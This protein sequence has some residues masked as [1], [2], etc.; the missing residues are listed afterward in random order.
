M[1]VINYQ[2]LYRDLLKSSKSGK[3]LKK[4]KKNKQI[5]NLFKAMDRQLK[6]AAK[7]QK[8]K[9]AEAQGLTMATAIVTGPKELGSLSLDHIASLQTSIQQDL[10][11]KNSGSILDGIDDLEQALSEARTLQEQGGD[12]G[13]TGYTDFLQDTL[14]ALQAIATPT[15]E[16]EADATQRES[17]ISDGITDI[18]AIRDLFGTGTVGDGG[19]VEDPVPDPE[20]E[21]VVPDAL[22]EWD[23]NK[24]FNDNSDYIIKDHEEAHELR[25]GTI[26]VSF[27]ADTSGGRHGLVAKD[28]YQYTDGGHMYMYQEGSKAVV[29][30]QSDDQTYYLETDS[31]AIENGEEYNMAFSFGE[32]GMELYLNGE[33]QDTSSY[34]GGMDES[35]G[36]SGNTNSW[37]IGATNWA[38]TN[39]HSTNKITH[40]HRGTIGTVKVFDEQ[41]SEEQIQTLAGVELTGSAPAE[42]ISSGANLVATFEAE[43]DFNGYSEYDM[44]DHE[45]E[46][47]LRNGTIEA[48]FNADD[49]SGTQSI[50][51]KDHTGFHDGGHVN[52][53]LDGDQLVVRLQSDDQSY[54]VKTAAGAI[55]AN[56]DYQASFS[57]GEGGMKLYLDGEE[58]DT[59]SYTGGLDSS[60]GG[61]GNES[62]M[63]IGA[64]N[65]LSSNDEAT[66][67]IVNHFNGTI[68]TVKIYDAAL[69]SSEVAAAAGIEPAEVV[70]EGP[71]PVTQSG[72][73]R[74]ASFQPEEDFNG[75][76]EYDLEAHE[77]EYMLRN[78]SIEAT[79][80]VDDT[81]GKQSI[82]AKDHSGYTDGGHVNMYLDGDQLVVRYQSDTTSYY[83]KSADG[84]I[85]ANTDYH[86]TFSFGEEGM[87]L[88]LDG[89]EI[90]TDSY[91]G[92]MDSSSGGSGNESSI[93]IGATNWGSTNDAATNSISNYLNGTIGVVNIY[94]AALSDSEVAAL[95][96]GEDIIVAPEEEQPTAQTFDSQIGNIV[97]QLDR[98]LERISDGDDSQEE[99]QETYYRM[100]NLRAELGRVSDDH[101]MTETVGALTSVLDQHITAMEPFTNKV[102]SYS[103]RQAA[104]DKVHS[105]LDASK[106]AL[107]SVTVRR[108]STEAWGAETV[109]SHLTAER[110]KASYSKAMQAATFKGVAA[111][112][113]PRGNSPVKF[114][115]STDD[116]GGPVEMSVDQSALLEAMSAPVADGKRTDRGD[117]KNALSPKF[118]GRA[119]SLAEQRD[120]GKPLASLAGR[121]IGA[122]N[123]V[124]R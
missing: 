4:I 112:A 1:K 69:T 33:L 66:N 115:V 85:D 11:G 51:A 92:G 77:D 72:A 35:S 80:N 18:Q 84:A 15:A 91:T 39:N 67:N 7:K 74:I 123:A 3:G 83:V 68:G 105:R 16:L 22:I 100:H 82:F 70:E 21:V 98:I 78:G 10:S 8:G 65:W 52:M 95:A 103:D 60:S 49:T 90:D 25:N 12:S 81:S 120:F 36:G 44:E 58:V 57:F 6:Q 116:Y 37:V 32:D 71:N 109:Q 121:V 50:F 104:L 102:V 97:G 107:K 27:T 46:F 2:S 38:A 73:T 76:N 20:P 64:T 122:F 89:E 19:I 17:M 42:V 93:V 41:L 23:V 119:K 88:Y 63:V 24:T 9:G 53:Y 55:E 75:S 48:T 101:E 13:T 108:I 45:D 94:D 31:G 26:E 111:A 87:K 118:D 14:T 110:A 54:Y 28:H 43:G 106:T 47:M 59:E 40:H 99:M 30:F 117:D 79:F 114:T 124:A 34:T 62:K 96:N 56:T 29:R 113:G 5:D 86:A 61:S